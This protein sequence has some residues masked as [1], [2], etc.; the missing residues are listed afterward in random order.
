MAGKGGMRRL[1]SRS[2]QVLTAKLRSEGHAPS[3]KGEK[4]PQNAE[5]AAEIRARAG[6]KW[7]QGSKRKALEIYRQGIREYPTDSLLWMSLGQRALEDDSFELAYFAFTSSV[8]TDAGNMDALETF[9][10]MALDRNDA[11][12]RSKVLSKLA[13]AVVDKPH[14]HQRAVSVA[15]ANRLDDAVK[16]IADSSDPVARAAARLHLYGDESSVAE[17]GEADKCLAEAL[18]C[19]AR[20]RF[21]RANELLDRLPQNEIPVYSL[22]MAIRKE[23][24]KERKKAAGRLLRQYMRAVPGDRWAIKQLRQL[25]ILS[26]YQLSRKG[27]PF[28]SKKS[29]KAYTPNEKKVS[30]LLH[31]SLPFNSAGYATRTHGLLVALRGEGWDVEGVTRLGYPFDMS[32][33]EDLQSTEP[34][35]VIDG[36][37]YHRLSTSKTLERKRPIQLY[38]DRYEKA[39][40]D[41]A[42]VNRPG[43]VHAASNHWNGLTAVSAANRL[44][45]PS[46]YEVRGLWEVTRGSRDPEWANGGMFKYMAKMEASAAEN[47]TQVIAITHA[48]KDELVRRGVNADKITVVPNGVNSKRFEPLER[49]VELATELG[50]RD[51]T[52]IGYI[53]SILDYEGLELLI[54]SALRLGRERDDFAVLLVG[55]GAELDKFSAQIEESGRSDLFRVT[56]RVPHE[57]V[58][59]YYSL[60]DIAPFPRLPLPV[61]EM[62]SP[63]KPFEAMAMGKAV[64]ASDVAALSEIVTPG[65]NGLLHDKGSVESLESALKLLLDDD[66]LRRRLGA[67]ARTWVETERDWSSL[68]GRVAEIY[69]YLTIENAEGR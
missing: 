55:D 25:D 60:V 57:Q 52:V 13:G 51:K 46:V 7:A 3:A 19:L 28:P 27:Y 16:I 65:L 63:L 35:D 37:P 30:Y 41:F 43:I 47:A 33:F 42:K 20:G 29:E 12:T 38:V 64:V 18:F 17:L 54:E 8:E 22:R 56:G 34:C 15:I 66:E 5:S 45:L 26:E 39:F 32:K 9:N 14:R 59:R 11:K 23:L 44:G 49:D 48:L 53:G 36:V 50:L 4:A 68:A 61:C 31:N 21:E 62:V 67:Q 58:E 6:E 24:R 40:I 1:L 69:D 10:E 2:R